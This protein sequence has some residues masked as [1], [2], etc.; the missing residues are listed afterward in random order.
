MSSDPVSHDPRN[1]S[2]VD[3]LRQGKP[4]GVVALG[5]RAAARV[6]PF[7]EEHTVDET[8]QRCVNAAALSARRSE[9]SPHATD[10]LVARAWHIAQNVHRL[11]V[12]SAVADMINLAAKACAN[13][14]SCAQ[15]VQDDLGTKDNPKERLV[16][17]AELAQSACYAAYRVGVSGEALAADLN[18]LGILSAELRGGAD[19]PFAVEAFGPLYSDEE[20]MRFWHNHPVRLK[21]GDRYLEFD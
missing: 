14:L 21:Q 11:N 2:F 12:D 5:A 3:G 4:W 15:R 6:I 19:S 9:L 20:R 7:V 10:A 17:H 8:F 16:D 13:A 1:A 18:Q